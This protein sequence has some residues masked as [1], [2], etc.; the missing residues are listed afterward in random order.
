MKVSIEYLG[1]ACFLL[2]CSGQ[3]I[4][5]DPYSDGSVPGCP[6]LRLDAEF[7]YC[8][9]GHGDHNAVSCVTL[10]PA[11]EPCFT[12]TEVLTDHDDA[13]GTKRGKNVIRVF[14]FGGTRVAHFGDLGRP[15]SAE[16]KAQLKDLDCALIPVGGFFTIDAKT[17]ADIVS[18]IRPALVIPMHYRSAD[19][20]YDVIAHLDDALPVLKASGAEI[21]PLRRGESVSVGK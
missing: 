6:D 4:V 21:L 11:Q 15:L 19:S 13:G 10:A 1:H 8:S 20:G 12:L 16:E 3:R 7:V 18:D 2:N 14:D 5:L 9:H 17:A